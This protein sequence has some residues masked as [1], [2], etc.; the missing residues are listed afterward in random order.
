MVLVLS[1]LL[2]QNR[3]FSLFFETY[4][5]AQLPFLVRLL[6]VARPNTAVHRSGSSGLKRGTSAGPEVFGEVG[7]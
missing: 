5:R 2:V 4:R 3:A 6:G 7:T 1:R